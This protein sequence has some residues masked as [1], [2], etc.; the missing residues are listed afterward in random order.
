MPMKPKYYPDEG[1]PET[2]EHDEF[3]E[4]ELFCDESLDVYVKL[5]GG[6]L[7]IGYMA[8]ADGLQL[9]EVPVIV[10]EEH[11]NGLSGLI[12]VSGRF[13]LEFK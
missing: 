1:E 3:R 4:K 13:T 12:A 8:S 6:G 7:Y 9:N 10:K 5:R 11:L 2:Y